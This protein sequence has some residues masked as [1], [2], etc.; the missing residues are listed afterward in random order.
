[1][2]GTHVEAWDDRIEKRYTVLVS[3]PHASQ[4]RLRVCVKPL[5]KIR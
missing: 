5:R 3:R 4:P 2:T 1:M